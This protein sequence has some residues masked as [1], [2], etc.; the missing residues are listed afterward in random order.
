MRISKRDWNKVY[1]RHVNQMAQFPVNEDVYVKNGLPSNNLD[2]I[3]VNINLARC[4]IIKFKDS[5]IPAA[6][7]RP[8]K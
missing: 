3:S 5:R 6:S 2:F 4:G 1:A 7:S 8:A